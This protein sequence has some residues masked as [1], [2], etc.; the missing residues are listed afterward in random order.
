MFTTGEVISR[1]DAAVSK[2]TEE[3]MNLTQARVLG[4][5]GSVLAA[6]GSMLL[7]V[8]LSVVA[9]VFGQREAWGELGNGSG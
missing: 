6:L 5:L 7:L 2:T 9:D 1:Q 8:V 3:R 4:V